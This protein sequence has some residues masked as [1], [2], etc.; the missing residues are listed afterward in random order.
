[1]TLNLFDTLPVGYTVSGSTTADSGQLVAVTNSGA[2]PFSMLTGT[3]S[4]YNGSVYLMQSFPLQ[5][6]IGGA[7]AFSPASGL[8]QLTLP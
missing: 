3:S 4:L 6:L 1:V 7:V 5:V 8:L 2:G